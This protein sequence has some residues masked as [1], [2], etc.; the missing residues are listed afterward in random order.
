MIRDH[1]KKKKCKNTNTWRNQTG[2][3][4]NQRGNLKIPKNKWQWIND[5]PKPM[6]CNESNAKREV[7]TNT[8][9]LPQ[10]MKRTSNKQP[11][12]TPKEP[13]KRRK[14]ATKPPKLAEGKKS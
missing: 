4:R 6:W 14:R 9:S 8:R 5:N 3:W 2:H 7:Y 1:L 10:A 12:L 13:R 11:N